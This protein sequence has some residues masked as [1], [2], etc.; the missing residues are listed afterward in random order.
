MSAFA[1]RN[2][3]NRQLRRPAVNIINTSS[4]DQQDYNNNKKYCKYDGR[5]L[6]FMQNIKNYRCVECGW[7]WVDEEEEEKLKQLKQQEEELEQQEQ[8]IPAAPPAPLGSIRGTKSKPGQ[9]AG[10]SNMEV[11][12]IELK[13]R[14][15][16]G[17]VRRSE[18][19]HRQREQNQY[20]GNDADLQRLIKKGYT[21]KDTDELVS[22]EGTFSV[23]PPGGY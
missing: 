1:F 11:E 9:R 3:N 20:K 2:N 23:S 18:Q 6:A 22:S 12:D 19:L 4:S 21:I 14:P 15:I 17:A 10:S 8:Q 13:I 7:I 5:L 16:P